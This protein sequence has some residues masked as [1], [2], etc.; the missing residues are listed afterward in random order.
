MM[1]YEEG[2]TLTDYLKQHQILEEN[3]ILNLL[4]PLLDG[5][6]VLHSAGIIHRDI[7]PDNIFIRQNGSPVLLDFGSARFAMG[8]QTNTLTTLLT[9]G[10]APMEQYYNDAKQQGPWSDIYSLG[11]VIYLMVTRLKPVESSK[12]SAAMIR[13]END[14]LIPF[15]I[16]HQKQYSP[17]FLYAIERA[18]MVLGE[19]RP[20]NIQEWEKILQSNDV[21][22][23]I[24]K[25]LISI[26]KTTKWLLSGFII[27]LIMVI[28]FLIPNSDQVDM[29]NVIRYPDS[30]NTHIITIEAA[31]SG[32]NDAQYLLSKMY[33]E[34]ETDKID[35]QKALKWLKKSSGNDNDDAKF[36]L[37]RMYIEGDGIPSNPTLGIQWL[38]AI[39]Q[40]EYE[41]AQYYLATLYEEGSNVTKDLKQAFKWYRKSAEQFNPDAQYKLGLMYDEGIGVILDKG[42]AEY[43]FKQAVSQGHEN[44]IKMLQER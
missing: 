29:K 25:S 14:P 30:S 24:S 31:N 26:N 16:A 6:K 28:F 38:E 13:G 15:Q 11:A 10:Y 2:I 34:G 3:D 12:R 33:F 21:K 32:D 19:D 41:P 23:T 7:K 4:M 20:Q 1:E 43:W 17:I 9:P 42:N 40:N 22:S 37:A 35:E 36:Y 27:V 44:A 8:S 18:I 5:L 39:A